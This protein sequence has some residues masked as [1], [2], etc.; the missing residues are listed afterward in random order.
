MIHFVLCVCLL[1]TWFVTVVLNVKLQ[2]GMFQTGKA[3]AIDMS[4]VTQEAVSNFVLA[5]FIYP[6]V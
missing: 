2:L 3:A 5:R 1:F 4:D 6:A